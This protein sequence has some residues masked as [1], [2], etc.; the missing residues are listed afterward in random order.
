MGVDRYF[1]ALARNDKPIVALET[2]EAQVTALASATAEMQLKSLRAVLVAAEQGRDPLAQVI[3]SYFE[4]TVEQSLT[5]TPTT[6]P[7]DDE[8]AYQRRLV[9]DRNAA[10]AEELSRLIT[11]GQRVF[12]VVGVGHLYGDTAIPR[13]LAERGFVVEVVPPSG[14]TVPMKPPPSSDVALSD[15]RVASVSVAWPSPPETK[16]MPIGE[17]LLE[18]EF[19]V[20]DS[21]V[22]THGKERMPRSM[23]LSTDLLYDSTILRAGKEVPGAE[24]WSEPIHVSSFPGRHYLIKKRHDHPGGCPGLGGW[25]VAWAERRRRHAIS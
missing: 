7:T 24:S 19:A 6:A 9:D 21:V 23:V 10:M 8:T 22:Y 17:A 16:V 2:V 3:D 11:D 20:S 5:D 13:L 4:G 25:R 12:V 18:A 1:L 14:R 15:L